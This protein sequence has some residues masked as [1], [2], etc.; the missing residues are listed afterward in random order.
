MAEEMATVTDIICLINIKHWNWGTAEH[1]EIGKYFRI[2][3][4]TKQTSLIVAI[5]FILLGTFLYSLT[6]AYILFFW[7]MYLM[8][9]RAPLI[10]TN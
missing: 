10:T 1:A 5:S 8:A 4:T 3:T 6:G 2:L 9:F 7:L